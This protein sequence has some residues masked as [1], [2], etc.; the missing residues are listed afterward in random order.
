MVLIAPARWPQRR[1]NRRHRSNDAPSCIVR[2]RAFSM[3]SSAASSSSEIS[4]GVSDPSIY[5]NYV[6][7]HLSIDKLIG[8]NYT[9]W[10]S[11]VRLWLKSQR[12]LDHL[13][14]KAPAL[15][16]AEVD[17]WEIID[18]QLC[19]VLKSTLDPS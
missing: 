13:A 14:L 5:T 15:S 17:R 3:A 8:A 4:S 12:Y 6:N 11:D 16:P 7:V 1:K 18:S 9:T 2:S 19:V 10:S